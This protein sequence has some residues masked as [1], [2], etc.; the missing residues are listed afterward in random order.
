M[1]YWSL[2]NNT[3]LNLVKMES[4]YDDNGN[5]V[6]NNH[7]YYNETLEI[8]DNNIKEEYTFDVYGNRTQYLV[9]NW[10]DNQWINY[11]K[12]EY[13]FDSNNNN[14]QLTLYDWDKYNNN[15]IDFNKQEWSFD[16]YAN[17]VERINYDWDKMY[18]RW[19]G[20]K[21]KYNYETQYP[22]SELI[23][24][25]DIQNQYAF[26]YKMIRSESFFQEGSGSDWINNAENLYY[27]SNQA[28]SIASNSELVNMYPN[29][30]ANMLFIHLLENYRQVIFELYDLQGRKLLVK[31]ITND[32]NISLK[33]FVNGIY[34][35][36]ILADG[37]K[38]IGNLIKD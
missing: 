19:L 38:Q 15:W 24:P 29:P 36:H 3:W 13:V 25:L 8:W 35:Y 26:K 28:L 22:L 16:E 30:V 20:N 14:I 27:F 12:K 17:I 18:S 33:G 21:V 5:N 31:D 37:N 11:G 34:I 32:M 4:V 6:Q 9:S 10:Y 23:I 1:C 2:E 7:Y